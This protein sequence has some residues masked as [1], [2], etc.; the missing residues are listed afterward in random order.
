ME[1]KEIDVNGGGWDGTVISSPDKIRISLADNHKGLGNDGVGFSAKAL[2]ALIEYVPK[3]NLYEVVRK[4]KQYA[5]KLEEAGI[6][7]TGVC[8]IDIDRSNGN[9][10]DASLGFYT[11]SLSFQKVSLL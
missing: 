10:K 3:D 11:P 8:N 9:I 7:Y 4:L 2:M 6:G 1:E 5:I